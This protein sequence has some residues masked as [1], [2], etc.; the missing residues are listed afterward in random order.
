MAAE[1]ANS[2]QIVPSKGD[3]DGSK[4]KAYE[5]M[6]NYSIHNP[7]VRAWAP[8]ACAALMCLHSVGQTR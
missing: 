7:E 8:S 1:T 3:P 2:V 4:F 5:T 6:Y